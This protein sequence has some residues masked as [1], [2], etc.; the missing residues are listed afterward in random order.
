MALVFREPWKYQR[1]PVWPTVELVSAIAGD[2]VANHHQRSGGRQ[3]VRLVLDMVA[4]RGAQHAGAAR[5]KPPRRM[6]LASADPE[7]AMSLVPGRITRE[8]KTHLL[9]R[10]PSP[11]RSAESFPSRMQY[12]AMRRPSARPQHRL[13][14]R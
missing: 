10:S 11:A 6:W 3:Q 7:T 1:S 5:G 9:S 4:C 14:R 12:R 8:A 13:C 2:L